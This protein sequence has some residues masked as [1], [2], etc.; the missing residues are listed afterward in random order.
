MKL[1]PG[2]PGKIE[3]TLIIE[4]AYFKTETIQLVCQ[5]MYEA[6]TFRLPRRLAD[7]KIISQK[8]SVDNAFKN[9][10]IRK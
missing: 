9:L 10:I 3:E 8:D 2:I 7:G 1:Y 6:C 5:G 4:L